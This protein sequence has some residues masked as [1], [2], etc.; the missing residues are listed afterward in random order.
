MKQSFPTFF[1]CQTFLIVL[2]TKPCEA[3]KRLRTQMGNVL[4]KKVGRQD[5]N[6]VGFEKGLESS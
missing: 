5:F 2:E 1:L 4:K 6:L 3:E